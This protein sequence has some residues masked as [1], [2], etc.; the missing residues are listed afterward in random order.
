VIVEAIVRVAVGLV[1]M[2]LNLLPNTPAPAWLADG[3]GVLQTIWSY[4]AGL[5]AWV[6]W[7]TFSTVFAA[8]M[9]C[10]SVSLTI[11]LVRVIASFLTG[12]GGSAA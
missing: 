2:I 1:R 9:L 3:D 5:G 8:V 10:L 11:R 4:G 12:G 7:T 6:P